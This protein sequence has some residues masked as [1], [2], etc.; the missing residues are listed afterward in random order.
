M[1][2]TSPTA[3]PANLSRAGAVRRFALWLLLLGGSLAAIGSLC[4]FSVWLFG[5]RSHTTIGWES[6]V[7]PG[8][9]L[10]ASFF[11][12]M[13]VGARGPIGRCATY[14]LLTAFVAGAVLVQDS[15]TLNYTCLGEGGGRLVQAGCSR[16]VPAGMLLTL[17]EIAFL[18]SPL[19][20][21]L[22]AIAGL[23]ARALEPRRRRAR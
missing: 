6:Y 15:A 13:W 10:M 7:I 12:T 21:F 2:A 8:L 16:S 3:S 14:A 23:I 18:F 19:V 20:A 4:G 9:L 17:T 5:A 22:A 1:E 11:G